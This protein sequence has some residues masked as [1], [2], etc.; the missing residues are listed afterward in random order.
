MRK[1]AEQFESA[2]D[3]SGLIA[4]F[5]KA[6]SE[7]Y[8]SVDRKTGELKE[9]Y[10]RMTRSA[11]QEIRRKITEQS[12]MA[13]K[14]IN[15][16]KDSEA[17]RGEKARS[18]AAAALEQARQT[19][20]DFEQGYSDGA[21]GKQLT[22]ELKNALAAA[23]SHFNNQLFRSAASDAFNIVMTAS[24]RVADILDEERRCSVIY[25][26]CLGELSEIKVLFEQFKSINYPFAETGGEYEIE[27]FTLFYRGD[28]DALSV[29]YQ[30]LETALQ[31]DVS[32]FT[33]EELID[34]RVDLNELRKDFLKATDT[35]FQRLHNY[36]LRSE[37]A[38][39]IAQSLQSEGYYQVECEEPDPLDALSFRFR[40]DITANE[41]QVNLIS[42][43]DGTGKFNMKAEML[44]R[45]E[46]IGN[47]GAEQRRNERRD[48]ICG[49]V[50]ESTLGKSLG[51]TATH[52]CKRGT[53]NR[54]SI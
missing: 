38:N 19:V 2:L 48:R 21:L 33:T 50:M 3:M 40:N 24:L 14:D 10:R 49:D 31:R 30:D 8:A 36:I 6:K 45:D 9:K 7:M 37:Y 29:R 44:D 32:R 42:L 1:I 27:D 39:I 15:E 18:V 43:P 5:E 47:G 11:E 35:A 53:Q 22:N 51:V 25:T 20:S 41:T 46:Y 4:A 54:N 26:Q 12:D 52:S 23:E 34:L 16:F 28:L 17:A 13:L